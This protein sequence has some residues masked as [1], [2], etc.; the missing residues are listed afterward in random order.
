MFKQFLA[1][2]AFMGAVG[3]ADAA[4]ADAPRA[5]QAHNTW[6]NNW[7]NSWGNHDRHSVRPARHHEVVKKAINQRVRNAEVPLLRRSG[8]KREFAG[9]RVDAVI[10]TLRPGHSRGRIGLIMNGE[11]VDAERIKGERVI[12][13]RPDGRYVFGRDIRSMRLDVRGRTFIKDIKIKMSRK[14]YAKDR[15]GNGFVYNNVSAQSARLIA[16]AILA[17]MSNDHYER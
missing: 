1:A 10:V 4:F 14:S 13:L 8:L 9:Y 16:R 2:I 7:N 15:S 17:Q 6:D 12:R 5:Q 3:A 11:R